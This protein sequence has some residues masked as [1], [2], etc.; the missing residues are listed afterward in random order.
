MLLGVLVLE[1]AGCTF[2]LMDEGNVRFVMQTGLNATLNNYEASEQFWEL[3]QRKVKIEI[4][5]LFIAEN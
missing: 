4:F 1:V 3:I 2:I 5:F